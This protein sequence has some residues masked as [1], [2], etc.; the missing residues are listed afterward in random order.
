MVRRRADAPAPHRRELAAERGRERLDVRHPPGRHLPRRRT[1]H[2][3]RR[4]RH[5]GVPPRQRVERP[6]GPHGRPLGRKHPVRRRSHRRVHP[7]RAERQLPLPGQLRQLQPHHPPEDLHGRLGVDLHRHRSLEAGDVHARRRRHLRQEPGLLG[8]GPDA[9]RRHERGQV[10]R[11]RAG[12]RGRAPGR[13]GRH[14]LELLRRRRRRPARRPELHHHRA[15]RLAAPEGAHADGQGAVHGQARAPGDGPRRQPPGAGRRALRGTCRSRQ[16]QPLRARLPLHRSLRTAAG[17]GPRAGAAAAPGRRARRRPQRQARELAG[18]RDPRPRGPPPEQL[19]GDRRHR[20]APDHR[21]RRVLRRLHLRRLALARLAP[22]DHR[23][24]PPRRAERL[25]LVGTREQGP[26]ERAPLQEPHV[27]PAPVRLCRSV[28]SRCA[29][30]GRQ[31][32]PGTAPRRDAGDLPLLLLPPRR[33]EERRG[34]RADRDGSLRSEPRRASSASRNQRPPWDASS[35]GG[36]RSPS[37]RS[38]S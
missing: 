38:G 16:R 28:R 22:R 5:D 10:L 21:R 7:G 19:G 6:L 25:P 37:S 29:A 2:G 17:A 27:R 36:S 3:R 31:A 32:D 13:G 1:A 18:L 14:R 12:P 24:G 20:R 34:G 33:D 4:R 9:A 30:G 35:S 23:L 15:P 26:L 8:H 11:G